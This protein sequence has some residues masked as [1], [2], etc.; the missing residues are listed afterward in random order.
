LYIP[1]GQQQKQE[2]TQLGEHIHFPS[3]ASGRHTPNF[4]RSI[5]RA[6]LSKTKW[7]YY[8]SPIDKVLHIN[9]NCVPQFSNFLGLALTD[10]AVDAVH[11]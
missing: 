9:A 10:Q 3:Y 5:S 4:R 6:N 8:L 7:D 2:T 1:E 11:Q